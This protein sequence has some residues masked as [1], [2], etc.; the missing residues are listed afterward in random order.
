[1]SDQDLEA[2]QKEIDGKMPPE[3][4]ERHKKFTACTTK[5]YNDLLA[6][7]GYNWVQ[8]YYKE[9]LSRSGGCKNELEGYSKCFWDFH[10]KY[11]DLKNYVAEIEGKPLPYDKKSMK[12]DFKENYSNYNYFLNKF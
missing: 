6:E 11:I 10:W 9:P 4:V 12:R 8:E 5:R 1:M 3:C 2:F 7:H